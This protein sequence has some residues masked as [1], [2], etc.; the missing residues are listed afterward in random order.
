MR[1]KRMR[2]ASKLRVGEIVEVRTYPEIRATLG[3][4]GTAEGL[5]F[6]GEMRNCCNQKFRVLRRVRKLVVENTNAGMRG[7]RDTYILD[8][9]NCDGNQHGGC[10]RFCFFLWKEAWLRRADKESR[11]L[12][13]LGNS[14]SGGS[15]RQAQHPLPPAAECQSTALLNATYP[16]S[17]WSPQQYIWDLTD[18]TFRFPRR[19][20]LIA[21]SLRQRIS[22][23]IRFR[24]PDQLSGRCRTTPFI[25]FEV[26][27]G[28]QVRVKNLN[29]IKV[30]LDSLGR[31]RG[32]A[33][34]KEMKRYCGQRFSVLRTVEQI[35]IEGTGEMRGLAHTVILKGA[36]CDGSANSLC[37]RN[38]Y[39]LWR[40]IWL[41]KA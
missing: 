23:K 9:A 3:E 16:L 28:D 41:D 29:E 31:N 27:P 38:C 22:R 6:Q 11:T 5:P 30:T 13:E 14:I 2:P 18:S 25:D 26:Q 4:A 1:T 34:T 10:Q 33:F 7:I 19:L 24:F 39:L 12:S 37:P 35:I 36:N 40:K 20:L 17:K 21:A 32:L 15:A 8:G